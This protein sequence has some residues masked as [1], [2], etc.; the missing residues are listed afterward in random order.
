MTNAVG[1][2]HN[3]NKIT[4]NGNSIL[5]YDMPNKIA[6]KINAGTSQSRSK[7]FLSVFILE[8]F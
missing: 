3:G 5:K 4:H 2:I 7:K 1:T 6:T 8:V